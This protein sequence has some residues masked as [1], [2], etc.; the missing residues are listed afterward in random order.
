[1]QELKE[2]LREDTR[3]ILQLKGVMETVTDKG[4][5]LPLEPEDRDLIIQVRVCARFGQRETH[6]NGN[7]IF[8]IVIAHFLFPWITVLY[9]KTMQISARLAERLILLE[10]RAGGQDEEGWREEEEKDGKVEEEVGDELESV[11]S[12]GAAAGGSS[13]QDSTMGSDE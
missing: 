2:T 9:I 7:V 5:G 10:S 12:T 3:L 11:S 8:V 6:G 13:S 4:Q 1:M